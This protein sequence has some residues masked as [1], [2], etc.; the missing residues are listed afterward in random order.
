LA[1]LLEKKNPTEV[2]ALADIIISKLK[3]LDLKNPTVSKDRMK[4]LQIAREMPESES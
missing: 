1:F 3:S 4:E 2:G